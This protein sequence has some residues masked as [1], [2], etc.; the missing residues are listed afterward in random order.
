[1]TSRP[2]AGNT[3]SYRHLQHQLQIQTSS[4]AAAPQPSAFL[5]RVFPPT[6]GHQD[7]RVFSLKRRI[8]G[9]QLI[10]PELMQTKTLVEDLHHLLGVGEVEPSESIVGWVSEG[11]LCDGKTIK[12]SQLNAQ[13]H[14]QTNFLKSR[15]FK[16][17]KASQNHSYEICRG[18]KKDKVT[19]CS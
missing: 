10:E 15:A 8:N 12:L 7:E 19:L 14:H 3:N 4:P 17:S 9:F 11:G 1:M 6:C 5:S 18:F 16:L 13:T 2:A